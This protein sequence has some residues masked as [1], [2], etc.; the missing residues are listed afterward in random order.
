MEAIA[1]APG[2]VTRIW[3][4]F[5]RVGSLK[6]TCVLQLGRHRNLRR[7]QVHLA[8]DERRKQHFARQREEDHVD[9][10]AGAGLE[11]LV[12]PFLHELPVLVRDAALHAPVDE[13]ERAIERH[14]DPHGPALD[15]L[16][17]VAG[18]RLQHGFANRERQLGFEDGGRKR[19]RDL[20]DRLRLLRA[21]CRHRMR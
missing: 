4:T 1:G 8:V 13:V 5:L 7:N 18:E 9:P 20:L 12:E 21:A 6:P 15:Q 16:V 14:A 17:E 2:P 10:V 3:L 19:G 11:V